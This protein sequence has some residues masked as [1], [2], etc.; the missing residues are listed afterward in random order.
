[1]QGWG[2]LAMEELW[3]NDKGELEHARAVHLQD[4]RPRTTCPTHFRV[5]F[6]DAPNREDTIHRSQGRRRAAA[7][8]RAVGVPRAAR[9]DRERRPTT[10]R[11]RVSMRRRPTSAFSPRS[12]RCAPRLDRM[13]DWVRHA[14]RGRSVACAAGAPCW[15]PSPPRRGPRRAKRARR[16]SVGADAASRHHRRRPPRVRGD[17]HRARR[18][19]RTPRPPRH[20]SSAF[21]SPHASASAAAAS[22]TLV[23]RR[24]DAARAVARRRRGLRP[25]P[26]ALRSGAAH[27]TGCDGGADCWSPPT[28]PRGSLGHAVARLRR[29]RV[30]RARA[31][32]RVLPVPGSPASPGTTRRR[33]SC[34]SSRPRRSRC[35]CSATATSGA[36]WSRCSARCRRDVRW[37]DAR[38]ADFPANER[39][40]TSRSCATDAPGGELARAPR[41]AYVLILTHSHALDFALV[42]A[43]ACCATTGRYLGLIGSKSKRNQFERRLRARGARTGAARAHRVPDRRGGHCDPQQGTRR[44]RRR[45]RRRD[46]SRCASVC[47]ARHAAARARGAR[48]VARCATGRRPST[49]DDAAPR[50]SPASPRPIRRS[51]PTTACRPHGSARRDPRGARRERRR[52]VHAD[53]DH[54][55][56]GQARRRHDR[57]G[58]Q[59]Q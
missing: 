53:E 2:W 11:R 25:R 18:A 16:W 28:T 42:D 39:R 27:R 33:C 51:S 5:D 34:M 56:R 46:C 7:D 4:S 24:G 1:M 9:C 6:F 8:A 23:V 40:P 10:A 31:P 14:L 26:R 59:R 35:W 52:Q 54:L 49:A 48:F 43:G 12:T 38:D 55:R 37:I 30:G 36:R 29:G 21:R 32:D 41:G 19:R 13:A 50:A 15:S 45:R 47:D 58:R 57:L 44:D 3:W 22:V 20:G 17:A